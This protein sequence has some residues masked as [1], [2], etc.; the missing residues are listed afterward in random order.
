MSPKQS[1]MVLQFSLCVKGSMWSVSLSERVPSRTLFGEV[2][3]F[4]IQWMLEERFK[5]RH[6]LMYDRYEEVT[7]KLEF[8]C[9]TH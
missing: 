5:N 2:E 9:A 4:S 3:A 6:V 8:A 1:L 7:K